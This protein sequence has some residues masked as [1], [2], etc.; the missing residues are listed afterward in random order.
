MKNLNILK[1]YLKLQYLLKLKSWLSLWF[2]FISIGVR[3]FDKT[4]F[5]LRS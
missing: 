4:D 5:Y 3:E 1:V 2:N